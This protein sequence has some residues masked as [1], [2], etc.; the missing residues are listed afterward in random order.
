MAILSRHCGILDIAAGEEVTST[1]FVA[2]NCPRIVA[3][4]AR[5]VNLVIRLKN[6]Q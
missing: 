1:N 5:L 3:G 4:V 6:S 2:A